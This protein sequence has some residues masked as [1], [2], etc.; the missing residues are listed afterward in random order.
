MKSFGLELK[1][2]SLQKSYVLSLIRQTVC[3]LP[4]LAM[5]GHGVKIYVAGKTCSLLLKYT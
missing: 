5:Y 2:F 4:T 3:S 1:S